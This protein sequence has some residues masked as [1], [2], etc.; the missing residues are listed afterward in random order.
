MDLYN[1]NTGKKK[2]QKLFKGRVGRMTLEMLNKLVIA[3]IKFL[4]I[5]DSQD[6]KG[7]TIE[8]YFLFYKRK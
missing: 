4:W 3:V 1:K 7:N 8:L 6:K 2:D 5:S